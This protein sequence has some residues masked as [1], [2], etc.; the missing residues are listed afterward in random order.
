MLTG[1]TD[2][3]AKQHSHIPA[4]QF[5]FQKGRSTTQAAFV[6]RHVTQAQRSTTPRNKV[7]CAFVDFT[8]AYDSVPQEQLWQL[9]RDQLHMP[10]GLLAAIQRLYR[11]AVYVL[12]DGHRCTGPV[13]CT[14]G[15][16]QGCPLSPLLFN[17]YISDLPHMLEQRCPTEGVP[18]GGE[19]R[20]RSIGYADDLSLL[21]ESQAGLQRMLDALHVYANN[22]ELEVNVGKTEVMVF[23]A[24]LG[25]QRATQEPYTYGPNQREIS[26]VSQF[27]F[28]GLFFSENGGTSIGVEDRTAALGRALQQTRRTANRVKLGDHVPTRLKL[29]DV[30]AVP[31]ANYGDVV[32][33]TAFLAP[34]KCLNNPLQRM[35]FSHLKQAAG[36]PS[37]T[38]SWPLLGELG[39]MPMQHGWWRH[40]VRFYNTAVSASGRRHSPLMAAALAADMRI[41]CDVEGTKRRAAEQTWSGQLL[42]ALGIL[43]EGLA[44]PTLQQAAKE[45]Q[46]LPLAEVLRL[47]DARYEQQRSNTEDPRDPAT[48]HRAAATYATWF[49]P[50]AGKV[51]AHAA[52]HTSRHACARARTNLRLRLGAVSTAVSRGARRRTPFPERRCPLCPSREGQAPGDLQHA[53]FE[54]EHMQQMLR[55]RCPHWASGPPGGATDLSVLYAGNIKRAMCYAEDAAEILEH[56][57]AV[58]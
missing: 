25:A 17:L 48:R 13:P 5:G 8:K 7:Y 46:Y 45:L 23:G 49:Q 33:G 15:I 42:A 28:L 39:L 21:T 51:L 26:R 35:L 38:P 41:A 32:W 9:L 30:Y 58:L 43:E 20:L 53:L 18:V 34:E 56:V 12:R 57:A 6:L 3:W 10:A 47:V 24:R 31:A 52:K 50:T 4:E 22:K 1:V 2:H 40:I 19:L 14:R 27:R 11:G 55:A 37:S 29:T 36:V 16:K 44:V 54:C